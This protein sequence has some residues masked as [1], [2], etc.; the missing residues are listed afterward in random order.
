LVGGSAPVA[1]VFIYDIKGNRSYY[2]EFLMTN[3]SRQ[4]LIDVNHLPQGNYIVKV[5]TA[6]TEETLRFIKQ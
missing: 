1:E 6:T 5:V 4:I 2:N 3:A